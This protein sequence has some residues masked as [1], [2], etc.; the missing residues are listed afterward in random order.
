MLR[1]R[2]IKL[3]IDHNKNE[4][5]SKIAQKLNIKPNENINFKINK[6]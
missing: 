4:L 5:K 1:I 2:Q 6:Q 3:P